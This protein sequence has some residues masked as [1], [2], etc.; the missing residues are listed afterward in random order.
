MMKARK[1]ITKAWLGSNGQEEYEM[2]I[3][4]NKQSLNHYEHQN[5]LASC[6]PS[7]GSTDWIDLDI[8]KK[9]IDIRLI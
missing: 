1:I 4:F 6:L 2:T 5:D 9:T 3:H 7:E 8:Q